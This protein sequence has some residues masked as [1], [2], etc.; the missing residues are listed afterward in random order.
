MAL[1]LLRP[2]LIAVFA[3]LVLFAAVRDLTSFTI[4]NWISVALAAAFVPAAFAIGLPLPVIG[5]CLL[6]G[7]GMLVI[8]VG[9]FAMNWIGG[10]DAKLMAAA[11]MWLGLQGLAPFVIYTALAGGALALALLAIRSSWVRPFA[12]GAPPW[13][14]RLATPDGKTPY[15]VAIAV[16]ALLAFPE[17]LLLHPPV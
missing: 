7:L 1:E 11:A 12:A 8:G 14:D 2:A 6:I 15:G 17:G 10:G 5:V 3:L 9:M 4:D 16:G 13:V